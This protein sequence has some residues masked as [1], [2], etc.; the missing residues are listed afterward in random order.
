MLERK[1]G[2]F[3]RPDPK[4]LVDPDVT[5]DAFSR[6]MSSIRIGDTVKITERDR[7]PQADQLLIDHV[8]LTDAAIVDIGASDGS[9]SLD[10]I[11]KLPAFGSYTAADLFLSLTATKA[12]GHVLVYDRDG[13]CI[14]VAG[15]WWAAWPRESGLIGALYRPLEALAARRA[16]QDVLL[17]NPELRAL[18]RS[19]PRITV[20][21]HDVFTPW[22]GP[23]PGIIKVANLLRRVYFTDAEITAALGV[24]HD[25]LDEGGHLLIVDDGTRYLDDVDGKVS[26]RAGLY[27]RAGDRF[28]LVAGTEADPEIADLVGALRR[29]ATSGTGA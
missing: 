17:I 25:S 5:P 12:A 14:L 9:T 22:P 27:R 26:A 8:E 2:R 28:A 19:D 29:G 21:E 3:F 16:R 13:R 11:R 6:A 4:V 15:R 10:L 7:H 20:R 18:M 23:A 24:L 1:L